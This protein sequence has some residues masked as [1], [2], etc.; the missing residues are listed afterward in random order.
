MDR[1]TAIRS[2]I[3]VANTKSFTKASDALDISRLQVSRHVQEIESWLQQRLLH[4][5]TRKVSLT[6]AG[7]Q[8]YVRCQRILDEAAALELEAN[9]R[10]DALIGT[11]RVASPIGLAQNLLIDIVEKFVSRYPQV[12]IDI[13]ASDQYSELVDE[14]VDVALRFTDTPADNLIARRLMAIDMAVCASQTYLD[15]VGEPKVAEE[16]S[17]HNCLTHLNTKNWSFVKDNQT[18]DVSVSG[19]IRAND[20]GTL[21]KVALNGKGIIRLP[22]DLANPLIEKG[23]LVSILRD[24]HCPSYALWAVYLSRSYQQPVVRQFIDFLVEC[25]KDDIKRK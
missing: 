14:R 12:V 17:E 23:E 1:L 18:I 4:R 25:W 6:D 8:A 22:C 2:F 16:L 9:N 3:E 20:L 11:I 10:K 21:V 13:L 5:T 15:S 7:E 24:C 19:N